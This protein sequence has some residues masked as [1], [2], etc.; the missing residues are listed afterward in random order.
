MESLVEPMENRTQSFMHGYLTNRLLPIPTFLV[1]CVM[2]VDPL[3]S[4]FYSKPVQNIV[5]YFTFVVVP[6]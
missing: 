6:I 5:P 2:L 4:T 1:T 3:S